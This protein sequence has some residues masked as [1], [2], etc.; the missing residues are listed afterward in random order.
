MAGTRGQGASSHTGQHNGEGGALRRGRALDRASM[1]AHDLLR[2]GK[3]KPRAAAIR[4]ARRIEPVK[5]LENQLELG[6]GDGVALVLEANDNPLVIATL[7]QNA[8]SCVVV[9]VGDGIS[10]HV[11]EHARHLVA[12]DERAK[13]RL[14][15]DLDLL[16]L[17]GKDGVKLIGNLLEHEAQINIA[18]R[19]HDIVK[20][21][22][23]DVEELL[24]ER[25]EAMRLL[26]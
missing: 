26:E 8:N 20:V 11:V 4:R 14:T 23:R 18:A 10:H 16:A 19:K 9:A 1:R 7:G 25:V 13:T 17:L 15:R 3:S 5:L 2:D 12:I 6:L 24:D 21:E 22:A